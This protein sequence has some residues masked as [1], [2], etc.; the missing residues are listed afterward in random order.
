M[1]NLYLKEAVFSFR[2][3]YQVYDGEKNPVYLCT[4]RAFALRRPVDVQDVQSGEIKYVIK[5]KIFSFMQT[6][7]IEAPNGEEV[8][9]V[10]KRLAF[11]KSRFTVSGSHGEYVLHGDFFAHNFSISKEDKE[12]VS[13]RK[14]VISWGDTYEISIADEEDIAFM[15]TLV[16]MI[17]RALHNKRRRRRRTG[18]VGIGAGA[19]RRSSR[20]GARRIIR[21]R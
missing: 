1:T 12:V 4:G 20:S 8:A 3:K 21:R 6:F 19:A 2:R 17:D 15:V 18:G 10:R 13:V 11:G 7:M 9:R 14:K 5:R 16:V